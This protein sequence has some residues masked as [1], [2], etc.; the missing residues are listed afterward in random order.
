M[1]MKRNA[2]KQL[3]EVR[4]SNFNKVATPSTE[5]KEETKPKTTRNTKSKNS[6]KNEVKTDT[7]NETEVKVDLSSILK[8]KKKLKKTQVSV[9]LDE[10]VLKI[11]NAFGEQNPREKS[12]L[13]NKVLRQVFG[14]PEED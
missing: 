2:K 12:R 1:S 5:V 3:E 7:N 6:T 13:V 8:P 9:Y 10:E 11:Y 14:L 4:E